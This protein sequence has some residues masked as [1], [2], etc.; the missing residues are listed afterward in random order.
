M[1]QHLSLNVHARHSFEFYRPKCISLY[2][3]FLPENRVKQEVNYDDV[4]LF[5]VRKSQDLQRRAEPEVILISVEKKKDVKKSRWKH[6]G[7]L[8]SSFCGR[9]YI[10]AW[11]LYIHAIYALKLFTADKTPDRELLR[12]SYLKNEKTDR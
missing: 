8:T 4:R 12:W 9:P 3:L 10:W 11:L 2:L 1:Y 6:R 7:S 5:I